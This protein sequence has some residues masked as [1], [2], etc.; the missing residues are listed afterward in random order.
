MISTIGRTSNNTRLARPVSGTYAACR[1]SDE[2]CGTASPGS[3][4]LLFGSFGNLFGLEYNI[5]THSNTVAT[6][7]KKPITIPQYTHDISHPFACE[8]RESFPSPLH[9]TMRYTHLA[10][11][12]SIS[13]SALISLV[14]A[15]SESPT[16]KIVT[17]MKPATLR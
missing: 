6:I 4:I 8:S 5:P 17:S 2:A 14:R 9:A 13:A 3:S 16:K 1:W 15:A 7:A 10:A 11:L 12:C